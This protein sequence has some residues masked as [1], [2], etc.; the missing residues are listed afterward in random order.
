MTT[1]LLEAVG[2]NRFGG[3]RTSLLNLFT[4]MFALD[5]QT[6]YIVLL[7][8]EEPA[9][10]PFPNVEQKV[11]SVAH[12]FG[13]RLEIQAKL[14]GLI[15]RERVDLTHF[16]K[17]LG[18]FGLPCPYIVTVHDLTTLLMKNSWVDVLY[19]RSAEPRTLHGAAQ[20]VAVSHDAA[21]DVER[22]YGIPQESIKVVYWAPDSRFG[23]DLDPDSIESARQRYDLPERYILFVGILA[24]KKNLPT[25]L[26]ALAQVRARSP[27]A[28][29]L[30]V[31]GRQYPQSSDTESVALVHQLG[32]DDHVR[33][34]GGVP[35]ED[36]PPLYAGA[37]LYVL[38]SLHEGFGI[39]LLEAMA[40]GVPVLTSGGGSL[41][42]VAGDAAWVVE[43]PL[44]VD[45]FSEAILRLLS[46]QVLRSDLIGRGY[47][48]VAEFSWEK[49]AQAMLEIYDSV[50]K[51]VEK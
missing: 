18:A 45:A 47:R 11:V 34:I 27:G 46:D 36:V 26:R 10:K 24:K 33:F 17:N 30:V 42:E 37:E 43:D 51:K 19:Y 6:H 20:L 2:I 29:D 39:P 5:R 14:P 28:P 50:L 23:R 31:A 25:L 38:P 40:C 35:N 16:T 49:S 1:I 7:S 13:V 8:A 4:H 9:L 48:R 12:R 32:L 44:D 41:P 15:R 22:V 21:R 3:T